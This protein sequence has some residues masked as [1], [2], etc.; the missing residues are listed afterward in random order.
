MKNNHVFITTTFITLFSMYCCAGSGLS[1][2]KIFK[3]SDRVL[4]I[5]IGPVWTKDIREFSPGGEKTAGELTLSYGRIWKSSLSLGLDIGFIWHVIEENALVVEKDSSS[6]IFYNKEIVTLKK[7]RRLIFPFTLFLQ[8]DPL[9]KKRIH[10]V[11]KVEAGL[12]GM[13]YLKKEYDEEDDKEVN[14]TEKHGSGY[15]IGYLGKG[16]VDLFYSLSKYFALFGGISLQWGKMERHVE[17][18]ENR[19]YYEELAG[20]GIHGGVRLIF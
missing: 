11:F 2:N 4:S 10:P 13:H 8:I 7:G 20:A 14:T 9:P 5:G 1:M 3:G 6:T 17:G 19:S 12:V 18:T 16:S 15:Y